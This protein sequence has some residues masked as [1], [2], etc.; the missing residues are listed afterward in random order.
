MS[1]A[2][3]NALALVRFGHGKGLGYFQLL[4][5]LAVV[6]GIVWAL[7]RPREPEQPKD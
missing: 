6:G 3:L 5:L 7:T 2:A 1:S 4:V